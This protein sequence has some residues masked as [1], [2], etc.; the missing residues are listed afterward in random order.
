[1]PAGLAPLRHCGRVYGRQHPPHPV[2]VGLRC[3]T[4]AG[5]L[6]APPCDRRVLRWRMA[7]HCKSALLMAAHCKSGLLMA[8][9]VHADQWGVP[10][11]QNG[12]VSTRAAGWAHRGQATRDR[13]R[14]D[15]GDTARLSACLD[16]E[17]L[18][19][20]VLRKAN[21][22]CPNAGGAVRWRYRG[23]LRSQQPVSDGLPSVAH[24]TLPARLAAEHASIVGIAGRPC[25]RRQRRLSAWR[26]PHHRS[27]PVHSQRI[28]SAST[29]RSIHPGG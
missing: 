22:F 29:G 26:S 16:A 24:S 2:H 23:V 12:P 28:R 21:P 20:V 18:H 25:E 8:A 13:D 1:M 11:R 9:G 7:A 6:S 19:V 5:L 15:A 4:R 17:R 10:D 14:R 27:F 3:L